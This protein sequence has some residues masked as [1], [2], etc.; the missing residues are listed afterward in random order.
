MTF[1][2]QVPQGALVRLSIHDLL[3]H[4]VRDLVEE[5][6]P[7]GVSSVAWDGR[8]DQGMVVAEDVYFILLRIGDRTWVRKIG[9][10]HEPR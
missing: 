1:F 9:V 6:R 10:R 8:N 7:A 4:R 3:G 5:D 2:Y